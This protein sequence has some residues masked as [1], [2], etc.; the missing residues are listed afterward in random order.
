MVKPP[1][2]RNNRN[3]YHAF[4]EVRRKGDWW[5]PEAI[6][7]AVGGYLQKPCIKTEMQT[8]CSNLQQNSS[9]EKAHLF[10]YI[11]ILRKNLSLT[12]FDV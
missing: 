2:V 11:D 1:W 7:V 8:I 10:Q 6:S 4:S 3:S 5:L 12:E 9:F